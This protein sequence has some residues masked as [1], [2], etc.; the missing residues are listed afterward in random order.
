M[1]DQFEKSE[2]YNQMVYDIQLAESQPMS[3][4]DDD[5]PKYNSG[6]LSQFGWLF[7][8]QL[9]LDF[10]NPLATK[11]VAIQSLVFN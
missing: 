6:F 7:W 9:K 2:L 4:E 1:T 5:A 8:R 3:D 11:V 10:K